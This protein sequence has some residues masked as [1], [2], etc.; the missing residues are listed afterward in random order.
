MEAKISGIS[1]RGSI[2]NQA[3]VFRFFLQWPE[4]Q[5]L[6]RP[7]RFIVES[8]A[9]PEM[10]AEAVKSRL[11]HLS[12]LEPFQHPHRSQVV[13]EGSLK[14]WG[15]LFSVPDFRHSEATHIIMRVLMIFESATGHRMD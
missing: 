15:D 10:W 8:Y 6:S 5:R 1:G 11:H 3:K 14:R 2:L 7:S 4:W 9:D 12:R 13:T